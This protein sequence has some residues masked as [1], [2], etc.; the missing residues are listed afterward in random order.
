MKMANA[1]MKG[2]KTYF[3]HQRLPSEPTIRMA[4]ATYKIQR[5]DTL[6]GIAQRHRVSLSSLKKANDM[7][8][9]KIK[10]GQVIQIPS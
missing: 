8:S 6:S 3:A 5:G 4:A 1:I 9:S 2:V 10:V 7:R